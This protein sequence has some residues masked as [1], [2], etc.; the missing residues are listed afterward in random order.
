M[1]TNEMT[2][3]KWI[4]SPRTGDIVVTYMQ[5]T[6]ITKTNKNRNQSIGYISCLQKRSEQYIYIKEEKVNFTNFLQTEGGKNIPCSISCLVSTETW[7]SFPTTLSLSLLL[8]ASSDF[9]SS[10]LDSKAVHLSCNCF[11]WAIDSCL[12]C[13]ACRDMFRSFVH[14]WM[15]S[16]LESWS[17]LFLSWKH[18]MCEY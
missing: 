3:M 5:C 7:L 1:V 17:S 9:N 6:N 18:L 13:W 16:S 2:A 11:I 8:S 10:L 4:Q 15:S 12:D 14:F